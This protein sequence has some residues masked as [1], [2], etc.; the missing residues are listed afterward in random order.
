MLRINPASRNIAGFYLEYRS[1]WLHFFFD[2]YLSIYYY[3]Y[4]A[5]L[6]CLIIDCFFIVNQVFLLLKIFFV[7]DA[8]RYYN[9][10]L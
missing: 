2:I 9:I 3:D 5:S 7:Q 8:S 6:F 10:E 4:I 1:S